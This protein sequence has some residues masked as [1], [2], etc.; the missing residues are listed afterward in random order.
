MLNKI[1]SIYSELSRS[2]RLVADVVLDQPEKILQLAIADAAELAAVSQPTVIRFCRTLGRSGYADFKLA[3]AQ[4]LATQAHYTQTTLNGNNSIEEVVHEVV[5]QAIN[6]LLSVRNGVDLQQLE[7]AL[8]IICRTQ[9]L[10]LF[11]LGASAVV[12]E[13]AQ[14]KLMRLSIPVGVHKDEHN[15]TIIASVLDSDSVVVVISHTGRTKSLLQS[16]R[17]AR[18]SGATILAVTRSGSPLA[19]MADVLLAT[20]IKEEANVYMP[21][22]SRLAHQAIFDV[23]IITL[24]LR[25]GMDTNQRLNR[26]KDNLNRLR[27]DL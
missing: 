26:V 9:R 25:L 21:M 3:L 8:N 19:N 7:A 13:D 6:S 14:Q 23:L 11:G 17:Q 1:K 5:D 27:E 15:Q 22:R 2:E 20:D 24:S 18:A 12:A 16:I 4:N 10:E